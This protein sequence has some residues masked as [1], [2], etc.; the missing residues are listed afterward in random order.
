MRS[1]LPNHSYHCNIRVLTRKK[2]EC[3]RN[4]PENNPGEKTVVLEKSHSKAGINVTLHKVEFSQKDTR[5]YLTVENVNPRTAVSFY[6]SSAIAVQG[7]KQYSTAYS[8]DVDYPQIKADI[9]PAIE[10]NGGVLFDP[11]DHKIQRS[12][13]FQFEATRQDTYDSFNFVFLVSIPK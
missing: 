13:K 5:A 7:N 6:E 1:S 11:L 8:F 2:N 9:P 3:Q 12:A 4:R 10:E